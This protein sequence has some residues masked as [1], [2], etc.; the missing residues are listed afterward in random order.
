MDNNSLRN[1]YKNNVTLAR[2][3]L[4]GFTEDR[5]GILKSAR[6]DEG[7]RTEADCRRALAQLLADENA[8]R[9]ILHLLAQLI[10]PDDPNLP[11]EYGR[12]GE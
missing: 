7:T 2:V 12:I 1:D 11:K 6:L 5:G 3:W 9:E 10:A 8:P 4:D